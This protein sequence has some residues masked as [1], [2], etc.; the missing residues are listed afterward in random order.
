[1]NP[2]F[3]VTEAHL[4]IRSDPVEN[5]QN[6]IGT[7]S[8]GDVVELLDGS[9]PFWWRIR[10]VGKSKE[11]SGFVAQRFLLSVPVIASDGKFP[12]TPARA[13]VFEEKGSTGLSS[14]LELHPPTQ[15]ASG[16]DVLRLT[17][18]RQVPF[19]WGL[20]LK[21]FESAG[22]AALK[23]YFEHSWGL[24]KFDSTVVKA[25]IVASASG[26]YQITHGSSKRVYELAV[27]QGQ[28]I[29]PSDLET[30][31]AYNKLWNEK[32][33][34]VDLAD[35]AQRIEIETLDLSPPVI[36]RQFAELDALEPLVIALSNDADEA[37][38]SLPKSFQTQGD[39]AELVAMFLRM[40]APQLDV[41]H[42]KLRLKDRA[43]SLGYV[44]AIENQDYSLPDGTKQA[45]TKGQLYQPYKT[46]VSWTTQDRRV[47]VRH[48][49]SGDWP[50]THEE[51]YAVEVFDPV[52]HSAEVVMYKQV[53]TTF[54][55]TWAKEQEL[56][57]DFVSFRFE[58][59]GSAY[60]TSGGE[61]L[62]EVIDRCDRDED[63]RRRCAVW[64]PIYEQKLTQGEILVRYLIIRR[65]LPGITPIKLPQLFIQEEL[66]YKSRWL[67][68]ELGELAHS[69]NLAP[70]EDRTILVEKSTQRTSEDRRT[71]TSIVDLAEVES[72][73][74]GSEIE[75]EARSSTES[76]SSSNW[77]VSASGSYGG[78]SASGSV[79]G[80][81]TVTAKQFAGRVEKLARKAATSLSRKNHQEVTSSTSVTTTVSSKEST[82]IK[83]KNINEGR[84]LN[85]FFYRLY[86]VY[87]GGIYIED[88]NLVVLPS[89]EAVAGSGLIL[90]RV[91]PRERISDALRLLSPDL[92]PAQIAGKDDQERKAT[93]E[94]YWRSI[95]SSFETTL[96][97]EYPE[98]PSGQKAANVT[99][100]VITMPKHGTALHELD[101]TEEV[102]AQIV[103]LR[104]ELKGH[105][106]Q[107]QACA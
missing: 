18:S 45:L 101:T 28:Q 98:I 3:L 97:S 56:A 12:V 87:R 44:L 76:T 100:S 69:I 23:K 43:A 64:L 78:A 61:L 6:V 99:A 57:K 47:E 31:E 84:T 68:P 7:L 107:S 42:A 54:D 26:K 25:N 5:D 93:T 2:L 38:K 29:K 58:R 22:T 77:N 85:L 86:N 15:D 24:E 52:P 40:K 102:P 32:L 65:P 41:Q 82:T 62:E 103:R 19:D 70:G 53:L 91:F 89:T 20:I 48:R 33:V 88:L 66:V 49:L 36:L 106:L 90:P 11:L 21:S 73:D 80:S 74:L 9:D 94:A 55:P 13:V 72:L 92:L 50:F 104:E 67:Y 59:I 1:M 34:G 60:I 75:N 30:E 14:F 81:N 71:A 96:K 35:A 8:Y 63:F 105:P 17:R 79:G 27:F 4:N 95:V 16:T 37:A 39:I 83:V 46:V 51:S 10:N